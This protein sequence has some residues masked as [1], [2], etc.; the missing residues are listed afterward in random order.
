M[1]RMKQ[2]MAIARA[3]RLIN[4]RLVRYWF[5]MI[6]AFFIALYFTMVFSYFHGSLSSYSGSVG[7]ISPRFLMSTIGMLYAVIFLVG[8][9][10]LA[11][12][13]RARDKRE[14]VTEVLDSRP[15]SNLELVAGRFMGVFLSSWIPMV[16]LAILIQLIGL[17]L[18]GL[19]IPVG[20]TI[21]I[22]SLFSFI[23][24][25]AVPALSFVIALVFFITLLVRNRITA[26][27]ILL[28]LIVFSYWATFNLPL[29][30]AMLFDIIGIGSMDFASDIVPHLA[31]PAGWLQRFSVLFAAFGLLGFSAAVHPCLDGGSRKKLTAGSIIVM[32][33]AFLLAGGV[34]YKNSGDIIV[35]ETWK[36]AHA[37]V[38]NEIVPDLKKI[39]GNVKVNPGK[40]LYLDLDITF[41]AP[42]EGSLEKA[43]FTL[44]P[45]Q[46]VK[47]AVD[48][49]GEPI[50]FTHENGL[51]ELNMPENLEPGEKTTVHLTIQGK[52][53]NRFAFLYSDVNP[54]NIKLSQL[55][56]L[57]VGVAPGILG[58]NAGLFDKSF[59]ALMP[60][61]RW[62]P[63]SGSERA[64]HD[65]RIRAV[66]FFYVDLKVDLPR[67]WLAAGPGRRL[68][69]EANSDGESFRFSPPAPVHEAALIASRF[70][71]RTMEVEGVTLEVLINKKHIKN[72]KMLADTEENI[73]EWEGGRL[74]EAKE[75]GLGYP[76]DA[77]TL[78]EVPNTLRCYGGGWRMDT[79]LV[80]PGMLLMREMGFPTANFEWAFRRF[81]MES[82]SEKSIQQ[83]KLERLKIF[84]S[85]DFSGGNIFAGVSRNFF[86]YQTSAKG[87][88]ALA[89]NYVMEDLST[90]LITE[91]RSFYSAHQLLKDDGLQ[92]AVFTSANYYGNRSSRKTS[93]VDEATE[94]A[95]AKPEVWDR[96]LNFSIKD[97]DPWEDPAR[98]VDVLILKGDAI[99]RSIMDTLGYEKT[100]LLLASIRQSHKGNSFRL[101]DVLE[102]GKMLGVDITGILADRLNST[103][104]P[105]FICEKAKIYRV[106]DSEDGSPRYQMLFTIRNDETAP[107][108]FRLAYEYTGEG[109]KTDNIK[110]D[111]IGLQGKSTIQF[112][113]IVSRPPAS[114][115]LE[116]YL[117]LNRG[118]FEIQLN[119]PDEEKI[120]VAKAIEGIE[121]LPYGI[122]QR[123]SIIID[124]LDSGFSITEEEKDNV[125]R[126]NTRKNLK[127]VTDQGLPIGQNYRIPPVWSRL[128]SSGSYGKYR[129]TIAVVEA[130]EGEKKAL[131]K[132][133]IDRAGQWGLELYIPAKQDIMP[134]RIWGIYH[135][136]VTDTTGNKHDLRFDSKSAPPGW[137]LLGNIDLPEGKTTVTVS[138]KTDGEF[139][140]ADAL[141]WT[142]S[143]RGP[144]I[145]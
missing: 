110:S 79:T 52:P 53:D 71:S 77:L 23:F 83:A 6:L 38:S 109:G 98:M 102:A 44:N 72:L 113:T 54:G 36:D 90:Q 139:V 80:P 86:L 1:I 5:F 138:N 55:R 128:E 27:V 103:N 49:S 64:R 30:Y 118:S 24:L 99:A 120:E 7:A 119:R 92:R 33:A 67:G 121:G 142:P 137:N 58:T 143:E 20:E 12:D 18:K 19:N 35:T 114:A 134:G 4:R 87:P 107:G 59:V 124:D 74:R 108:F 85:N 32:I 100:G 46:E 21:E 117:S 10:F 66:D 106:T 126:V 56:L 123:A 61:L 14:R 48:S 136:M 8:T 9:I 13:V 104:L 94:L 97:M 115:F 82:D 76:Y 112:G 63:A 96:V 37:A 116:P 125:M 15:Y 70:D 144:S 141:R 89:L 84:F 51:L 25:M 60:G 91:T 41:G 135:L 22:F 62:L 101:N 43:L 133:D 131:F 3:Q 16:V 45:G 11:F 81:R 34:Y 111:P 132:T 68:I 17:I 65:P 140:A 95:V 93:I 145:K 31:T 57:V 40:D 42:D 73:R 75:Y 2:V 127:V 78:V 122:S 88:E 130:G 129:H 29:I 50:A 69:V 47:R 26:T 105:G 39:T 28:I